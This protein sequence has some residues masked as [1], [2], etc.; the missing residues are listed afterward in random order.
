[1]LG[2]L[3]SLAL[4]MGASDTEINNSLNKV[5]KKPFPQT[6]IAQLRIYPVANN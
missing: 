1:M 6:V 3:D 2:E 4:G 5:L